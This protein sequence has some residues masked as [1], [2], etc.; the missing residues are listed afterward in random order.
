MYNLISYKIVYPNFQVQ[1][2][3]TPIQ[4]S[5]NNP[6]YNTTTLLTIPIVELPAGGVYRFQFTNPTLL[7]LTLDTFL[8]QQSNI[9]SISANQDTFSQGSYNLA[10]VVSST[11]TVIGYQVTRQTTETL[12]IQG[13][14]FTIDTTNLSN[15]QV[16]TVSLP[17]YIQMQLG[18]EAENTAYNAQV[19][20]IYP[21]SSFYTNPSIINPQ[22]WVIT[23]P[24][25]IQYNVGVSQVSG[26][27]YTIGFNVLDIYGNDI[28]FTIN[29]EGLSN[30]V[31]NST[32]TIGQDFVPELPVAQFSNI[33]PM[34]MI[35]DGQY[36]Y[37][38]FTTVGYADGIDAGYQV[39]FKELIGAEATQNSN[40]QVVYYLLRAISL[41]G[42]KYG[43][44]IYGLLLGSQPIGGYTEPLM[45]NPFL[46]IATTSNV[47]QTLQ[48]DS[49]ILTT[50]LSCSSGSSAAVS[51]TTTTNSTSSST[52]TTAT[53]T[54]SSSTTTTTKTTKIS[55]TDLFTSPL[56]VLIIILALIAVV[57][58][59]V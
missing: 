23:S 57:L 52:T 29:D 15:Q 59:V 49:Q 41:R 36:N 8:V 20:T 46:P 42:S 21:T 19:Q 2:I 26:S 55:L 54:T 22:N 44:K 40:N 35:Q 38:N 39:Y 34:Q 6:L 47:N 14:S 30:S 58:F 25:G 53:T 50:I 13:D 16:V 1:Q 7:K 33:N 10:G 9:S 11:G 37:G 28:A 43:M 24:F 51:S 48:S 32:P 12:Y 4:G 27:M 5:S 18:L 17:T 31:F 56:A 45:I 3:A